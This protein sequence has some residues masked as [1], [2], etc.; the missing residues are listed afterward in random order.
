[1]NKP[2]FI[3]KTNEV[4]RTFEDEIKNIR[5]VGK[6]EFGKPKLKELTISA[7]IKNY[8]F[9]IYLCNLERLEN[10]F[11]QL[12]MLR[13]LCEDLIAISYLL[14]LSDKES[15][16]ILI[17]NQ[18]RK[19]K[20]TLESQEKYFKKY[21]KGQ[22]VVPA[23]KYPTFEEYKNH[24]KTLNI[25]ERHLPSVQKMSVKVG[26]GDLYEFLYMAT[27]KSVH[28]DVGTLLGMGWGNYNK[29][30]NEVDL[31]FSFEHNFKQYYS[32]V[33]FYSS[34]IFI[35]QTKRFSKVIDTNKIIKKLLPLIDGYKDIDWP[36]IISFSQ[37]NIEKPSEIIRLFN[38]A[39]SK[40][41]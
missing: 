5:Y 21:N 19:E 23:N 7:Y 14:E 37:L 12:P 24:Q 41:K 26:L 38:R 25:T 9:I 17:S 39:L 11:F 8:D 4:Y 30:N 36:T 10:A 6:I 34:F 3:I 31:N 16:D 27:S 18:L 40:Y 33:L 35:E 13:G 29:E 2:N 20:R 32:F 22:L 15:D 1:M 28:F